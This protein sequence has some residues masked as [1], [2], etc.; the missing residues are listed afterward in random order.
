MDG[1][2]GAASRSSSSS[3]INISSFSSARFSMSHLQTQP[4]AHPQTTAPGSGSHP[5]AHF[6][7]ECV[8]GYFVFDEPLHNPGAFAAIPPNFGLVPSKTWRGL[9]EDVRRLNKE[10]GGKAQY[11]VVFAARHGEGF[12]NVAEAKYGTEAW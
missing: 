8:Q 5:H 3:T 12:H 6:G 4:P 9:V 11:K 7:F 10:A 1:P 2:C